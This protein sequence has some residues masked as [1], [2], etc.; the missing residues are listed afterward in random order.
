[1]RVEFLSGR[2]DL[3]QGVLLEC[4]DQLLQGQLDARL[5]AL[6]GLFRHGQCGFEAV[7]D[8]QQFACELLDGEL[9]RLGDVFLGAAAD[10]LALGLGAQPGVVVFGRLQFELAKLLLDAGQRI[11]MFVPS[12]TRTPPEAV[13]LSA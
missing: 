1:M 11:G 13:P 4:R 9:V 12:P 10:V 5:E 2:V 8:R 7:L 3:D 6:H